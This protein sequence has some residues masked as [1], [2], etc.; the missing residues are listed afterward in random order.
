M[1]GKLSVLCPAWAIVASSSAIAQAGDSGSGLPEQALSL[2]IVLV[3]LSVMFA[4]FL[5]RRAKALDERVQRVRIF[6][7]GLVMALCL[8]LVLT[9]LYVLASML[10]VWMQQGLSS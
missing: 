6:L 7:Q 4:R 3:V 8:S 9:C 5:T 10:L 1:S 2:F